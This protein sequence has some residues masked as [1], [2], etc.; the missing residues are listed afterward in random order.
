MSEQLADHRQGFG[1]RRSDA[2]I[3]HAIKD[4]NILSAVVSGI[5]AA[6]LVGWLAT[7][8]AFGRLF[9]AAIE[10]LNRSDNPLLQKKML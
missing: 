3:L 9:T 1:A 8:V 10:R 6:V 5:G 4:V 7:R 2:A